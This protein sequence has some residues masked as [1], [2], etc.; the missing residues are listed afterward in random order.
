[1][2]VSLT[3]FIEALVESMLTCLA[4]LAAWFW[5]SP[6]P[7]PFTASPTTSPMSTS[8]A[9]GQDTSLIY[10]SINPLQVQVPAAFSDFVERLLRLTSVSH[11]VVLISLLYLSRLTHKHGFCG[12]QGTENGAFTVSLMLANKYLDE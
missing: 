4:Q 8:S 10:G 1:M 2:S 7:T 3:T 6:R 9:P 11:S 12:P 5:F